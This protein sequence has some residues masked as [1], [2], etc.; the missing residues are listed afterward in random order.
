VRARFSTALIAAGAGLALA[1]AAVVALALP[2]LLGALNT[3]VEGVAAV[4]GVYTAVLAVGLLAAARVAS[5]LGARRLAA[6]GFSLF[7]LAS[8][9]CAVA[10]SLAALLAARGVQALGGAGALVGAFDLLDAAGRGRRVWLVVVVFGA[11]VGPALGGVLTQAFDWRAIFVAQAPLGAA[12][13]MVALR[14]RAAEHGEL[15]GCLPIRPGVC[16][17]LVSAALTGVLFLLVLE[18]VAGLGASPLAGAAA[19]TVLPL[20]ALFSAR[21]AIGDAPV[22]AAAGCLLVAA[23]TACLAFMPGPSL[24][25]TVAPQLLAGTGMGLALPAL[26]GN[27]LPERTPREAARLLTSRHAGILLALA[28]LAPIVSSQLDRATR[29]AQ[30]R[31][32]A[33]ALDARLSLPTKF[34]LGRTVAGGVA[35]VDPR[36]QIRRALAAVRPR[37]SSSERSQFDRLATRADNTV[38]A[39]VQDAFRD[40]FVLCGLFA[41][42]AGTVL[43]PLVE[44][45]RLASALA[46]MIAVPLYIALHAALVPAS[47]SLGDPCRPHLPPGAAVGAGTLETLALGALD[48]TACHFGSS[49]EELVL[50]LL[51]AKE[52]ARYQRVHHADLG[53]LL[54][55]LRQILR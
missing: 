26:A 45:R 33:L 39:A 10:P 54:S 13:G 16:L 48:R 5:S 7:A 44:L 51:D 23:G 43:V 17:A 18:L 24:W 2:P 20:A 55:L 22:R 49:R 12:A 31:G 47:V 53:P 34:A 19:V 36:A 8:V 28:L 9:G 11:A 41:L 27:L 6:A 15:S 46:V 38:V 14:S 25:W 35:P 29:L 1:D 40:V 42:L 32:I 37:L 50:A 52:A 3:T 4:L 21:W 30:E